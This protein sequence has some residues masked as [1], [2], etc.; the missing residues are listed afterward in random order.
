MRLKWNLKCVVANVLLVGCCS[1]AF[2]SPFGIDELKKEA[3]DKCLSMASRA[4]KG[5]WNLWDCTQ[6]TLEFYT[7]RLNLRNEE[8]QEWGI[9][10]PENIDLPFAKI[11][12]SLYL[13][14]NGICKSPWTW[15]GVSDY[16]EMGQADYSSSHL[17]FRYL[18]SN[19][20]EWLAFAKPEQHIVYLGCL[21]FLKDCPAN[22]PATRA[23]DFVHEGLHM[24]EYTYFSEYGHMKGPVGRCTE[25]G[26]SCDWYYWHKLTDFS[27]GYFWMWGRSSD[28]K[29]QLFHSA[30][31]AQVEFL[32][33]LADYAADWVPA[34]IRLLAEV[35]ANHR[36]E[37]RFRNLV[38]FRCGEPRP[39]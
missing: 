23:S 24:W 15:H 1:L 36:L 14:R 13:L 11:L 28:G 33:D 19:L 27:A 2:S 18:P 6:D 22:N 35:E 38:A 4:E 10:Q 20:T 17:G 31:Q 34:N 12:N 32:S 3:N 29:R 21:L 9:D 26:E 39:W 7:E 16:I 30:N 25:Y 8:W 37:T 5:L